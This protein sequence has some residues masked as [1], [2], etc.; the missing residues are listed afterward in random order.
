MSDSIDPAGLPFRVA[1][2]S[3]NRPPILLRN[4]LL[5]IADVVVNDEPQRQ[6]YQDAFD[7]AGIQPRRL[8][9]LGYKPKSIGALRRWMAENVPDPADPF[10]LQSDDDLTA[11]VPLMRFTTDPI[12]NLRDLVGIIWETYIAAA[13]AGAG[14]FGWAHVANPGRRSVAKPWNLRCWI[15]SVFGQIDREIKFDPRFY[16]MEDIDL[17]LEHMKRHR[18]VWRD[19][20]FT[21]RTL[22]WTQGGISITRTEERVREAPQMI[23]DKHGRVMFPTGRPGYFNLALQ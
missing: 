13:D 23:N 5:P 2:P 12:T 9:A 3:H 7:R 18:I 4:P 8:H 22:F 19:D 11:F 16:Q 6:L 20:R 10:L 17:S 21:T 1:I 15:D 14:L